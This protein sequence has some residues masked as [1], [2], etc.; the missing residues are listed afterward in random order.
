MSAGVG[1]VKAVFT[2]VLGDSAVQRIGAL[3]EE[4][5]EECRGGADEFQAPAFGKVSASGRTATGIHYRL[6]SAHRKQHSSARPPTTALT[7]DRTTHAVTTGNQLIYT[8]T[9]ST[10]STFLSPF[11]SLTAAS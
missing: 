8:I 10:K 7:S 6:Q 2:A 1:G 9:I 4:E 5:E 3:V 11:E